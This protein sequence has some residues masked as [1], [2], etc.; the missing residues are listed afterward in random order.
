M[1]RSHA[2]SEPAA[3]LFTSLDGHLKRN[4]SQLMQRP[5]SK[6]A[7]VRACFIS[8]VDCMASA[9][10]ASVVG[11]TRYEGPRRAPLL[12]CEHS[13]HRAPHIRR[14]MPEGCL[15]DVL[16]ALQPQQQQDSPG[17]GPTGWV[18]CPVAC[19]HSDLHAVLVATTQLPRGS[20]RR[21]THTHQLLWLAHRRLTAG[22]SCWF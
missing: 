9:D 18:H 5:S 4:H 20:R 16:A 13:R 22:T 17:G 8:S 10:P 15:D 6:S 7:C 21:T 2:A 14:C 19:E 12:G 1:H 11:H 3:S